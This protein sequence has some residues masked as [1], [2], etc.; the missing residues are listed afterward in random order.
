[1]PPI[2]V[3]THCHLTDRRLA[4][5]AQD[6]LERAKSAGVAIVIAATSHLADAAEAV[7][8]AMRFEQVY[9]TAGMHPHQAGEAPAD[10]AARLEALLAQ[11]GP[12]AV[13]IGEIGLDYH[14]EHSPREAQQWVFAEQL[15][16]AVRLGRPVVVHTREALDD[17]LGILRESGIDGGRVLLHSFTGGPEQARPALDRGFHV[18]FSGIVTFKN[19]AELRESARLAPLER[20]MV[21][22]DAPWLSPEPVR[23]QRVNEPANVLY[24]ACRLAELRGLSLREFAQATTANACRFF[25]LPMP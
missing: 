9:A 14:Y 15:A 3:D 6:V 22:T 1:M 18:S 25:G 12:R 10:L 7:A 2:L 5:Q 23:A 11:A 4:D 17:T 16:L 24:V 20:L 19:A 8:L 21:E 13:A